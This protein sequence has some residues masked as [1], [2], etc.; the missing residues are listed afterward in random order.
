MKL[1]LTNCADRPLVVKKWDSGAGFAVLVRD[2]SGA[3][4]RLSEA[5]RKYFQAGKGLQIALLKPS[6]AIE[7]S[8]PLADLFDMKTTGEYTVLA[9]VPV[10]GDVDAVLTAAPL[11]VRIDRKPA[12]PGK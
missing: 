2:Q 7:Q 5:G 6:E 8:I 9:S 10:V 12:A 1:A 11:K 3:E 4:V